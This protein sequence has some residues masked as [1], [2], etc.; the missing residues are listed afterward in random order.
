[1]GVNPLLLERYDLDYII[2]SDAGKPF[3][4]EEQPTESGLQVLRAS[5]SILM[6]QVRGLEFDRM[7]HRNKAKV[8]PKPLWFSID[9]TIGESQ[10]GD[11]AFASTIRTH[12]KKLSKAEISVLTRHAGSL[13]EARIERF[14]PE[15]RNW[16]DE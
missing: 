9:S 12:L 2:I 6:E 15:I 16:K 13:L 5:I 10:P 8:G 4:I 14:A 3:E 1:M 7:K 11:A